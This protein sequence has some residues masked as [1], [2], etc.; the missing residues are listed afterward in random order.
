MQSEATTPDQY[1]AELPDDRR[2]VMT[3]LRKVIIDNLPKGFKETMNYGMIG[4]VVPS[5]LYPDGYH[6]DPSLPLPFLAI[7]SQ[8]NL[9]AVYHMGIY[10]DPKLL[11]WFQKAYSE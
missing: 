2:A 11:N 7:A 10:S 3:E 9:I 1:I 5:E 6:C 8:K 4:Y